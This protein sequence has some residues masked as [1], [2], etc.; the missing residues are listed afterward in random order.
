MAHFTVIASPEKEKKGWRACAV[1]QASSMEA[2]AYQARALR[3][4]GGL[5]FVP[6][7]A[8]FRVRRATRGEVRL[9]VAF[10]H[11]FG[12]LGV[13]LGSDAERDSFLARRRKL[14]LSFFMGLYIDP[15]AMRRRYLEDSTGSGSVP[16]SSGGIEAAGEEATTEVDHEAVIAEVEALGEPAGLAAAADSLNLGEFAQAASDAID[17]SS[18]EAHLAAILASAEAND[19]GKGRD[20]SFDLGIL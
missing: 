17:E 6:R 20:E 13:L 14:L 19:G 9:M 7:P 2:A 15:E 10:F 16:D 3:Q 12:A 1:L 4:S 11:S 8:R 5:A 18:Q